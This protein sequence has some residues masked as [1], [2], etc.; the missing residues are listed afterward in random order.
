MKYQIN[1]NQ[2]GFLMKDGRFVKTIYSGT[3]HFLKTFGYEVIV[4]D[5]EGL[6]GFNKVPKEILLKEDETFAAKV[7][8]VVIPQGF[9]GSRIDRIFLDY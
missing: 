5:M 1:Q 3:Y 4:E 9:I 6:V 8:H 2:C 7:L